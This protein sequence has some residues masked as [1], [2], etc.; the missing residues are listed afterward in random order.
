MAGESLLVLIGLVAAWFLGYRSQYRKNKRNKS[1]SSDSAFGKD[2]FI[3]LNYLLNDEPDG[4]IDIFISSLELSAKTLQSCLALGTLLR[5]R[6]KV[7]RS[8]S[9]FQEL[10]AWPQ[11]SSDELDNV[12]V[13]L[14]KS[15]IAAGLLDRAEGLLEELQSANSE[16]K[17]QALV[18]GLTVYQLEKDWLK[19]IATLEELL[20]I[21]VSSQ[22]GLYL[23]Q[24]SHFFCELAEGEIAVQHNASA[25]EYLKKAFQMDKNNV[26]TSILLGKLEIH[27]KNYKEAIKALS[28]IKQ[29]DKKFVSEA[30]PLILNCYQKSAQNKKLQKFIQ[31]GLDSSSSAIVLLGITGY[32]EEESGRQAASDFLLEKLKERP[33]LRMLSRALLLAANRSD[34]NDKVGSTPDV[35]DTESLLLFHNI[36][37]DYIKTQALYRCDN[38]GFQLKSLHWMCPGC[39]SWGD[40]KPEHVMPGG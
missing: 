14:V 26:R 25:R 36:L 32:I 28:R 24:A 29:Q 39:S 37:K 12:K 40:V 2:Y 22:R 9:V 18:Q 38:C 27:L 8:I 11:L 20:K 10:L 4:A 3:G 5:R 1:S 35:I 21:C 30:F 6:G 23:K 17:K 15:Y 7:D 16:I 34:G 19:G 31:E 13:E 33:S